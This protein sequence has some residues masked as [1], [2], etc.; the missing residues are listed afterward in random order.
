MGQASTEAILVKEMLVK[1]SACK[2][3]MDVTEDYLGAFP[4]TLKRKISDSDAF[5]LLIPKSSD[6]SY[7]CDPD[8]W[9]HKEICYALTF[10]DV[11]N[12]PSRIVPVTFD[13]DFKFPSKDELGDIAEISDYNFI[14]YDTNST[15]SAN[16]VIRALGIKKKYITAT[17][18]ASIVTVM[19][20]IIAI[21]VWPDK[22]SEYV[23]VESNQFETALS[24]FNTF[25][26]FINSS[27]VYVNQYLSWYLSELSNGSDT[28]MNTEF[29]EV[30][31]KNY[32]IRLVT[33]AYLSLSNGDLN[34][35]FNEEEIRKYIDECYNNIPKENRY[36]ISLKSKS[37]EERTK[38][39]EIILDETINTLNTDPTLQSIDNE[40][41]LQLK[42]V[43]MS[44]LWPY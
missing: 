15:E 33:L 43:L 19:A 11:K 2:V 18:I 40:G 30:Y 44:K 24:R 12:K 6:Y 36:P 41:V 31:V 23:Y 20:I 34:K 10:K 3:F 28:R 9:V 4:Q 38:D 39:I 8:N 1:D 42:S 16:K 27:G 29:N 37:N 17:I 5:L 26:E 25:N 7:L 35:S 22:K 21:K 32:C 13:R 14:Y